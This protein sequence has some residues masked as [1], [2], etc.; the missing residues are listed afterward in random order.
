VYVKSTA[1]HNREMIDNIIQGNRELKKKTSP[2]LI[3][4]A[5]RSAALYNEARRKGA[6]HD[7]KKFAEVYDKVHNLFP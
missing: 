3:K 7:P 5:E 2:E 1:Q 6:L 4:V